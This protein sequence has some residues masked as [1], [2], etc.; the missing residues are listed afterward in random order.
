M[1]DSSH[2][3][4]LP[5]EILD[6]VSDNMDDKEFMSFISKNKQLRRY[7]I[8]NELNA[9]TT[10]GKSGKNQ[11]LS[12]LVLK[13]FLDN[14]KENDN[15]CFN[16]TY[17]ND[18]QFFKYKLPK[19]ISEL[20]KQYRFKK[21]NAHL[22]LLLAVANSDLEYELP[23]LI[24]IYNNIDNKT[25]KFFCDFTVNASNTIGN[26]I[27]GQFQLF[28]ILENI[29]LSEQDRIN[30]I[31]HLISL[32]TPFDY[33]S[34]KEAFY[35]LEQNHNIFEYLKKIHDF[36][37]YPI[38]N[39]NILETLNDKET[40]VIINARNAQLDTL[41]NFLIRENYETYAKVIINKGCNLNMAGKGFKTHL[42]EAINNKCFLIAKILIEEKKVS[43]KI[44]DNN[45]DNPLDYAILSKNK[46]ICELL[47]ANGADLNLYGSSQEPP[48][49]N[50]IRYAGKELS[51][52]LIQSGA[53][54]DQK[55]KY[56][57]TALTIAIKWEFFDIAKDLIERNADVHVIDYEKNN[58]LISAAESK[59]DNIDIL[60]I[61]LDKGLNIDHFNKYGYTALYNAISTENSKATQLLLSR[62]A[63]IKLKDSTGK[64]YL[65]FA[66]EKGNYSG[67]K[68]FIEQGLDVNAK[69]INGF[70]PLHY[71][72]NYNNYSLDF[73]SQRFDIVKLLIQN[74]ANVNDVTNDG[75][76]PLEL[77][78]STG[79]LELV[80]FLRE[81]GANLVFDTKNNKS[82][83]LH[84]A[85]RKNFKNIAEFLLQLNSDLVN[86]LD[87]EDY[88]PVYWAIGLKRTEMVELLFK[89]SP[90]PY[91][92]KGNLHTYLHVACGTDAIDIVKLL[93]NEGYDVNALNYNNETPLHYAVMYGKTAI[94]KF[95]LEK[96]ADIT[97]KNNSGQSVFEIMRFG[98]DREL[99][100]RILINHKNLIDSRNIQNNVSSKAQLKEPIESSTKSNADDNAQPNQLL[101]NE[102]AQ[103]NSSIK[104]SPSKKNIIFNI[105]KPLGLIL[106]VTGLA[107]LSDR[108]IFKTNA[109]PRFFNYCFKTLKNSNNY[110]NYLEKATEQ[111]AKIIQRNFNS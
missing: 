48:I 58:L 50:A 110:R 24:Y 2:F 15:L 85:C 29:S 95:L 30:K 108:F 53:D 4:Y 44:S 78:V 96:G 86:S 31:M 43:L 33:N 12:F 76:Y 69:D 109:L 91:I 7:Y 82:N 77:A 38:I 98:P 106:Y 20:L 1:F 41:L 18:F 64:T 84:T 35:I 19:T 94:V 57:E 32:G 6:L 56:N 65:H 74:N 59:K 88:T 52:L 79:N 13:N 87:H 101:T 3:K 42:I 102:N 47:I 93:Y 34:L 104:D 83:I 97:I 27:A 111:A 105:L 49:H 81:K 100:Y 54:I 107:I 45:Y 73:S 71:A 5:S 89:Y 37:E 66:C 62:G 92:Q 68:F 55:N 67:V 14:L 21:F 36:R 10:N 26:L 51:Q 61:L 40:R 63:D 60:N 75:D 23:N 25:K 103:N 16:I 99:I 8:L 11:L 80:K 72:L 39:W 28:E 17:F 9:L 46:D 90:K 70:T 22:E